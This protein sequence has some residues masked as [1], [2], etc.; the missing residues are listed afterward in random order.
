MGNTTKTVSF[1]FKN[2]YKDGRGTDAFIRAAEMTKKEFLKMCSALYDARGTMADDFEF[3]MVRI[4]N[5]KRRNDY[6]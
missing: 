1:H 5:H 6:G 3:M 4:N 2:R